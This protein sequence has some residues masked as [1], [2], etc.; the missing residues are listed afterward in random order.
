MVANSAHEVILPSRGNSGFMDD[1]E[2][3][4]IEAPATESE[5][6][7]TL[8]VSKVNDIVKREKAHVAERVRQQMQAE[9]QA[10]LEKIRAESAV[11]PAA[12]GE[13]DTSEI[14]RRVYDKFMQDLQ[15]HR[16]EVERKPQEDELKTIADQYYLKMGKGSQLFEDFNEVMG[17]FEPDKFPNAV[18]LAA[19]MENT[20]EIMYELAN[21]PSKLLEI[22]SLAKT[23]PKLATKQLERL[24]KSISQNLEAKTNNV[25]APPPLSKLKSS[26]VGMDSGKMTLKDFKN[27]PWLKG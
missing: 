16:D 23:S 15:K 4:G 1:I 27:A 9:H 17:D 25:S 2:A 5:P 8:P 7:K 13:N 26:S 18:M 21:N 20:P 14:E 10:E 22:D 19:Q 24:S 12:T 3:S 11:Q 6:E